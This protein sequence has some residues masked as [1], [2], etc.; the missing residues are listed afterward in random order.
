MHSE[1]SLWVIFILA[2]WSMLAGAKMGSLVRRITILE[3]RLGAIQAR[4]GI[5]K[6]TP[7]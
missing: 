3:S 6:D 7:S 2:A 4:I 1:I 5:P